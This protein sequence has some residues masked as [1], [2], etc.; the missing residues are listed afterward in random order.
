M[1]N[2]RILFL[3][4]FFVAILI[5]V[6]TNVHAVTLTGQMT[7][8]FT[9]TIHYTGGSKT[10]TD[11]QV[12]GSWS[13]DTTT[14]GL[15]ISGTFGTSGLSGT[16]SGSYNST[17][18][19]ITGTWTL[20]GSTSSS[21]P[22][23]FPLSNPSGFRPGIDPYVFLGNISGPAPTAQGPVNFEIAMTCEIRMS[24]EQRVSTSGYITSGTWSGT[25]N[26]TYSVAGPMPASGTFSVPFSGTWTGTWDDAYN[27]DNSTLS[28]QCQGTFDGAGTYMVTPPVGAPIPLTI[29]V[30]GT[31]VNAIIMAQDGQVSWNG[32]WQEVLQTGG[33]TG[34]HDGYGGDYS[35][36]LGSEPQFPFSISGTVSGGGSY[37]DAATGAD[38]TYNFTGDFSGTINK[39]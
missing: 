5:L 19:K 15:T 3:K 16:F 9:G 6:C 39:L 8:S 26:G 37:H 2:I 20:P 14:L 34:V 30:Q 4:A 35:L 18:Q 31:Y 27:I 10:V 11:G 33:T 38:I 21:G 22:F 28:G 32:S 17:S 13:Y 36:T 1:N 12:G 29:R 7:G 25:A 23:E 24:T